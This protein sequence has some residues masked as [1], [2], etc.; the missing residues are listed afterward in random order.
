[1]SHATSKIMGLVAL[2][3]STGAAPD[4]RA[5]WFPVSRTLHA[6]AAAGTSSHMPPDLEAGQ[7]FGSRTHSASVIDPLTGASANASVTSILTAFGAE[8]GLRADINGS[9]STTIGVPRGAEATNTLVFD[10]ATL[11][12]W[13]LQHYTFATR[14]HGEVRLRD[15]NSGTVI[16]TGFP[17]D[18]TMGQAAI[19]TPFNLLPGRYELFVT[20]GPSLQAGTGGSASGTLIFTGP[21]IPEPAGAA[22]LLVT[23]AFAAARPR[24]SSSVWSPA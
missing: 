9:L 16:F 21:P 17:Q 22:A 14:Y 8:P 6:R 24:R 12:T 15:V 7:A 13:Q 18:R 19:I 3:L 20:G 1:M 10:V 2:V 11:Q 23:V 5:N 4:A